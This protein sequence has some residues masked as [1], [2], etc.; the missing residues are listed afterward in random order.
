MYKESHRTFSE[1]ALFGTCTWP[2]N[3][4]RKPSQKKRAP[5]AKG[6]FEKTHC[7]D[8]HWSRDRF[9]EIYLEAENY[10]SCTPPL[11]ASNKERTQRGLLSPLFARKGHIKLRGNQTGT[12]FFSQDRSNDNGVASWISRPPKSTQGE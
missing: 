6:V 1:L 2:P 10:T 11:A 4:F 3:P 8:S 7:C 9:T 12:P 5:R